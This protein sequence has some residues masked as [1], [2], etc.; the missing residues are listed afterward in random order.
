LIKFPNSVE[1]VPSIPSEEISLFNILI[2][3]NQRKKKK[4]K[5][6]RKEE[7]K[8]HFNDSFIRRRI[9]TSDSSLNT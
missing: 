1:I 3:Y 8:V 5:E 6:K 9:I 7:N 2:F 4:E